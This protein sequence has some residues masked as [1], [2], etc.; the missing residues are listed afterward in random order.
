MPAS[1]RKAT[2]LVVEDDPELRALYRTAL[3]L[4]GYAVIAVADGLDALRR[5]DDER[6]E[7]MVL[8]LGLP[9]ISGQDVQRELASRTETRDI[10]IVVVTGSDTGN[11][12]HRDF[13]CIFRKPVEPQSLVSA[14]ADCLRRL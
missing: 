9:F 11:L 12:D 1:T 7:A 4:A 6:P 8:D 2:V 5:I 14:V 10:P 13:A 3:M